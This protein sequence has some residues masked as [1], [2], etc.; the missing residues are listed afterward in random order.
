MGFNGWATFIRWT[1]NCIGF[2]TRNSY[3]VSRFVLLFFFVISD[4]YNDIASR[5]LL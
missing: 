2:G 5:V 1:I 3:K 4:M